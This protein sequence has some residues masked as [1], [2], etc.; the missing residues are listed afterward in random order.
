MV[1]ITQPGREQSEPGRLSLKDEKTVGVDI[2]TKAKECGLKGVLLQKKKKKVAA[3][4]GS[5]SGDKGLREKH[6]SKI[7]MLLT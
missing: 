7:F 1:E 3:D 5:F 6:T 4:T 2:F